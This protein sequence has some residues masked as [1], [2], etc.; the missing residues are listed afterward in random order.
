VDLAHSVP[1]FDIRKGA[2][3]AAAGVYQVPDAIHLV[4]VDPGVGPDRLD[5]CIETSKGTWLVGPDN[6]VLLPAADRAGGVLRAY[7]IDASKIDFR[8]PLATFHARDVLAPVA[9]ALACGVQASSLG[10][11]LTVDQLVEAPFSTCARDGVSVLAE[12]LETD[13]FGS[14]RFNVPSERME[15][16]GLRA[17]MLEIA[18]R[19]NTLEVPLVR[20]FADVGVGEPAAMIDSSGWLTLALNRASAD[21]RFGAE[22][23]GPVR[24]R[25][26]T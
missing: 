13:R 22:I 19:H 18:M 4:V 12:V 21:E 6:G 2:A 11:P 7:G 3:T 10:S 25:A 23:G 14:I 8:S 9:A 5:I 20:T 17:D 16:L 15:E 24:L 26:L 1:P